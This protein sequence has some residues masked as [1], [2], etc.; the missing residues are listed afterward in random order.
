MT[1]KSAVVGPLATTCTISKR[2]P[3]SEGSARSQNEGGEWIRTVV[4]FSVRVVD[5]GG[6]EMRR[7]GGKYILSMKIAVPSLGLFGCF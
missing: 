7:N 4:V 1:P 6:H 3:S 5:L 2:R